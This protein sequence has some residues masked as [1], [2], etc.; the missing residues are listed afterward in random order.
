MLNLQFEKE[1]LKKLSVHIPMCT[2]QTGTTRV[3][4]RELEC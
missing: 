1:N 2:L 3:E 4:L